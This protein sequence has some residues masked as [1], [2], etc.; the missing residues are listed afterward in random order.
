[1]GAPAIVTD[2]NASLPPDLV[3]DL[4]L[5]VVPMEIH[6]DGLVYADGIDLSPS[7]FYRLLETT[8]TLATTSPPQPGAFLRAFRDASATTS[9]V[10]CLTLSAELSAT[11]AAALRA[12]EEAR[13][14]LPELR[15]TVVDTRTAG[16]AQGLVALAAARHAAAGGSAD[17]VLRTVHRRMGDVCLYGYLESLRYLWRSGRVPRVLM[18]MGELLD[19]KPVLQLVDGKIGMVERPRTS[20]KA[21][22]RLV[23][24]AAA[25]LAGR[26]GR[27]AVMH[28]AAPDPAHELAERLQAALRP[29]ELFVTE[30]TP[31]I[32]A[33]TGPGLVGC[34][35]HPADDV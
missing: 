8:P 6:H 31:V 25:R 22:D 1:M 23:A 24:L 12:R 14:E 17:D 28:A 21:M 18:W 29:V 35:L 7:E 34:A 16:T 4:P 11:H 26:P 20:R 5:S 9:E 3:R 15:V 30:F 19:V 32:G 33:H 10:V 27:V 2:S 13:K